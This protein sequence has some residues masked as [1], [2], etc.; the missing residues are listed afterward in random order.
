MNSGLY[1]ACAGL[2]ARSQALDLTAN[3]LAN[4]SSSGY[5]RQVPTFRSLL[6][7]NQISGTA[8]NVANAVNQFG[9]LGGSRTDLGQGG[10]EHTGSDLDFAIQG[11]GFFVVQA[12]GG[13]LYTR[14][15]N[16]HVDGTG[17]LATPEGYPVLGSQGP[18]TIPPG[19]ASVSP[20]GTISVDGALAGQ[21]QV[22]DF[23]PGATLSTAGNS[24]LTASGASER[25]ALAAQII[26]GDLEGSNVNGVTAAV[27]LVALQRNADMLERALTTFHS[28]FNRIAAQDLSR[29]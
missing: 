10:L 11:G 26:Q 7:S 20:N 29:V 21:I 9:V 12:P 2:L 28:D 22:V 27:G 16:F 25:P 13:R 17:H 6:A 5:K 1:A 3:N 15:G 18:L 14:N 4:L 8:T 24:Y 19:K 23:A